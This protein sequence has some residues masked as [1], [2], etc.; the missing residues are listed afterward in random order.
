M[1][2]DL[3]VYSLISIFIYSMDFGPLKS[4]LRFFHFGP[5]FIFFVSP[6]DKISLS[7][8][9]SLYLTF[10][11]CAASASAAGSGANEKNFE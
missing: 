3:Y 8:S 11:S 1:Y 10:T 4:A 9:L 2:F 6:C 5:F 7:L